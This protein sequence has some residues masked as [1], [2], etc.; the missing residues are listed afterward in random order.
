MIKEFMQILDTW[1]VPGPAGTLLLNDAILYGRP[2]L[3]Q[4]FIEAGARVN[5]PVADI[6]R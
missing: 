4:L 6:T 5:S 2:D 3:C 1:N